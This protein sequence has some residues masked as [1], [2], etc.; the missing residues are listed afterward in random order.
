MRTTWFPIGTLLLLST[1]P[2]FGQTL[3]EV[4]GQVADPAGASITGAN[5]TITN[6][7]TNASRAAV[8]NEAGVYSFPALPPGT[9]NVRVEKSGFKSANT[10]QVDVQVQ[11][12]VRLDF[13]LAIGQ[14]SES[15]EVTGAAALLQAENS[16][17]GTV[18]ENKRIV[19][20]PL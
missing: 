8:T 16:T 6:V 12:T 18:I 11:Q 1:L 13:A 10:N 9:Y 5:V 2:A 20:L 15:I 14:V 3:G 7:N 19:E 4:T 17:V